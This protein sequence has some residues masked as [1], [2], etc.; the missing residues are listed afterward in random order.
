MFSLKKLE[1][2]VE[3]YKKTKDQLEFELNMASS[4][5]ETSLT[6]LKMHYEERQKGL[7]PQ[8]LKNVSCSFC[9]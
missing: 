7:L 4:D 1:K 5:Y 3:F 9:V 6:K 8:D 2:E